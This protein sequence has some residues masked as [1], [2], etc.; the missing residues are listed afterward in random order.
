MNS[1]N[2]DINDAL[3]LC[4]NGGYSGDLFREV[5]F[6]F[7]NVLFEQIWINLSDIISDEFSIPL[8]WKSFNG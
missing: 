4:T 8:H 3:G 5:P 6:D 2:K 1:I 7:E